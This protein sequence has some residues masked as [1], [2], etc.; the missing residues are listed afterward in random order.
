MKFFLFYFL[1][2]FSAKASLE[3]TE[4]PS[5]CYNS[6][7]LPE[8]SVALLLKEPA[9][10]SFPISPS[11]LK[12]G[13]WSLEYKK[14]IQDILPEFNPNQLLSLCDEILK[15]K[16]HQEVTLFDSSFTKALMSSILEQIPKFNKNQLIEILYFYKEIGLKPDEAFVHLW[17]QAS[18]EKQ[19]EF[20]SFERYYIRIF[21]VDL[22]IPPLNNPYDLNSGSV[23]SQLN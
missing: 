20:Q 5:N 21:F 1:F 15:F 14:Q 6:F 2:F 19:R 3:V 13:L 8:N 17:R 22:G 9:E 18:L 10:T 16:I 12:Q 7:Y 23:E 4:N 11:P